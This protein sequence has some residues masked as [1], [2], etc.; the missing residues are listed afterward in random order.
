MLVNI[1]NEFAVLPVSFYAIHEVLVAL[2][3]LQ[4]AIGGKAMVRLVVEREQREKDLLGGALFAIRKEFFDGR[5]RAVARAMCCFDGEI[6]GFVQQYASFTGAVVG[7]CQ[8]PVQ[9]GKRMIK[10]RV[11]L[12]A[13]PFVGDKVFSDFFHFSK[14]PSGLRPPHQHCRPIESEPV[15]GFW[16]EWVVLFL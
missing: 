6:H 16:L 15:S 1:A 10:G 13:P 12:P 2:A 4:G 5:F 11:P 7:N 3:G 8:S 9:T 14:M